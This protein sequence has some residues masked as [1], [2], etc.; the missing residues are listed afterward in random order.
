MKNTLCGIVKNEEP[1]LLEWI[2]Y[3]KAVGMDAFVIYDN[4]STDKSYDLLCAL[5]RAGVVK[6]YRQHE[7]DGGSPQLKAYNHCIRNHADGTDLLTFIDA[8]EFLAPAAGVDL[9]T[10]IT[11]VFSDSPD[12]NAMG[13]NWKVFGS[14]GEKVKRP[15]FLIERFQHCDLN[16]SSVIKTVVKPEAVQEMFIH[17]AELKSGRYGDELGRP[18][19][20]RDAPGG[21]PGSIGVASASKVQLNHYMVKSREEFEIKRARGNA[22][23]TQDHPA[24]YK[25]FNDEYFQQFDLNHMQDSSAMRHLEKTRHYYDELCQIVAGHR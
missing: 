4:L 2:A 16:P 15:G 20:F 24:K 18:V 22:N 1:Y 7:N 3:H 10:H 21:V 9:K 19:T 23:Y 25:R 5:D 17:Y 8:D 11:Q 12:M 13:I 14:S 6:T